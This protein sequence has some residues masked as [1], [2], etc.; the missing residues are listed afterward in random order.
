ME[1]HKKPLLKQL[2][3]MGKAVFT[4]NGNSVTK[5][6]DMIS[7]NTQ[8]D[9]V[10]YFLQC[11]DI[12]MVDL[13]LEE[14]RTYQNFEKP[15][16][17]KKLDIALDEFIEAGDTFLNRYLGACNS[18]S[19]NYKCKGFSFVGN[20]S[21]NY[22]D[23]IFDVQDGVVKDIYECINFKCDIRGINKSE[24]IEIDKSEDPF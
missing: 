15:L 19:C 6:D 13:L 3:Q 16:F 7:L 11:L 21:S 17:I 8:A 20:N 23:L 24:H 14:N 1:A 22:F 4:T 12:N 10:L 5:K 2:A 9:A 18:E